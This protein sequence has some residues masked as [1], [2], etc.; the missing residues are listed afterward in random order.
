MS[1]TEAPTQ[2]QMVNVNDQLVEFSNLLNALRFL[3]EEISTAKPDYKN[4]QDVCS[5]Y[6]ENYLKSDSFSKRFVSYLK[7]Y[8]I[9]QMTEVV[10]T[11]IK[12]SLDSQLENYLLSKLDERIEQ[13]LSRRGQ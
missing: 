10:S 12:E 5:E 3:Y 6:L 9:P 4:V 1:T 2:V 11:E 7:R 13:I 8:Q